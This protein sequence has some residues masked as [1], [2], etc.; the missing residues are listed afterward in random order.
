MELKV[1]QYI[2]HKAQQWD[3][4]VEILQYSGRGMFG[5]T[6]VGLAMDGEI[7]DILIP[8]AHMA[9]EVEPGSQEAAEIEEVLDDLGNAQEDSLGLRRVYY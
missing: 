2:S 5:S 9:L 6:T 7:K 8:L 4:D 1:A 3:I